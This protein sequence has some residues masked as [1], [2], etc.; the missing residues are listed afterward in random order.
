[1]EDVKAAREVVNES[2]ISRSE[3]FHLICQ[4][5]IAMA[6]LTCYEAMPGVTRL[7]QAWLV[8]DDEIGTVEVSLSLE[9][10]SDSGEEDKLVSL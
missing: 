4:N 5:L 6:Y 2:T 8:V 9:V 7:L 3:V 10:L 1:V